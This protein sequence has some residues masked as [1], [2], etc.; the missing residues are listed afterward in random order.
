MT[1]P[2]DLARLGD[3]LIAAARRTTHTRRA[4]R[5]RLALAAVTGA[6]AFLALTP[7]A[8]DPSH[9]NLALV[10]ADSYE[11]PRCDRPRAAR[12]PLVACKPRMVLNRPYAIN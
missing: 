3:D 1:L 11:R 10:A 8:L 12:S 4:R 9:R 7:A 5:R 2:P 6:M